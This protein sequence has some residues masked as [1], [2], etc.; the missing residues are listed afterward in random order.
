MFRLQAHPSIWQTVEFP[1]PASDGE[2]WETV[3]V[4]VRFRTDGDPE[5]IAAAAENN[6]ALRDVLS[7]QIVDVRQTDATVDELLMVPA[8]LGAISKAFA[9]VL[10]GEAAAGNSKSLS[11]G[12]TAS[13]KPRRTRRKTA[14]PSESR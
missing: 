11:A 10:S 2:A 14:Q 8:I 7:E 4:D 6:T 5:A 3:A 1:Y 12:R 9:N 13:T